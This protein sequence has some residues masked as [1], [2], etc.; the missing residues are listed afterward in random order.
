MTARSCSKRL[1][2]DIEAGSLLHHRRRV[3]LRQVDLPAHAVVAGKAVARRDPDRRRTA[4]A[5]PTP[6]RGIVFQ[7]YSVFPHLTVEENLILSAT[8]STP[9]R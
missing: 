5:E 6:D 3:G 8:N 1:N 2:L 7:R 4:A 9:R